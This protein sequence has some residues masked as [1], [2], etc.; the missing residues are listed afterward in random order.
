[1]AK[2]KRASSKNDLKTNRVGR[3]SRSGVW[4]DTVNFWFIL[5][6][7]FLVPLIFTT[8]TFDPFDLIKNYVFRVI[9]ALMLFFSALK[10]VLQKEVRFS[11]HPASYFLIAFLVWVLIATVDSVVPMTSFIGKYR[12]FEGLI[13]FFTYGMFFWLAVDN[14]AKD[15]RRIETAVK[16]ALFT[17]ILISIYGIMQFLGYDFFKWGALPFEARRSFA[18][19]GNPALLAGYLVTIFPLAL[20]M[21]IFSNRPFNLALGAIATILSFTC[22]I[23]AFNRTSWIAALLALICLTVIIW[24]LH[25]KKAVEKWAINNMVLTVGVLVLV[26]AFLTVVSQL[27]KT[28]LTVTERIKQ[29][30]EFGGGSFAHRL[31]I[32][33]AGL[34]MINADPLTGLGPDTFRATSRMYQ[35]ERYGH[36]APDIVADNAHNYELQITTGTGM[37]GFLF[38]GAFVIYVFLE[39]L[40]V[41]Y[42]RAFA[43]KGKIHFESTQ[44]LA[45]LGVN[46][47]LLLSFL[48]YFF[49][50]LTS[51][52]VIGSTLMWWFSFAAILSQGVSLKEKTIRLS[53]AA[54]AIGLALLIPLLGLFVYFNTL[55]LIADRYY[56]RAKGATGYPAFI[57]EQE[58]LIKKAMQFN[59]WQWDYPAEM[60]RS[61]FIAYRYTNNREFLERALHY[62]LL[63]ESIDPYEADVKAILTQIYLERSQYD[64][65]S[66]AEAEAVAIKMT[67]L[68]P[69]HYVSW[70]LLGECYYLQGR[71]PEAIE[72]FE[73]AIRNNPRSD[74]AYY[75]LSKAYEK[76]GNKEMASRYMKKALEINPRVG[77]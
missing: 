58:M 76:L 66:V 77:K 8:Q 25:R 43:E 68:M 7:I 32:W 44:D 65:A 26:F 69:H 75:Y 71:L 5:L 52:S 64:Q 48:A 63:A 2:K 46:L 19:L 74:Q 15:R 11:Y 9:V 36:I 3:D 70:L 6:A 33:K 1:M 56:F 13:A 38:L 72:A 23:T 21:A 39:G 34:R 57:Y 17:G 35:G 45:G 27:Q 20:G 16:V 42:L 54:K 62:A 24:Y 47:G 60:A 67:E 53:S 14:F 73:E 4:V 31:E 10:L 49:Q 59:P 29:L 40:R 51:V 30:T 61:F 18:T 41:I 12:R 22:L 28:P 55:L 37:I 50:L